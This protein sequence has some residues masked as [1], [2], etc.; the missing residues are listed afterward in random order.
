MN[1]DLANEL[2]M[3]YFDGENNDIEEAQLKQHLKTCKHCNDEFKCMNEIFESVENTN[4]VE[5]PES[6]ELK[7]MEKVECFESK[8]KE[9]NA[10]LLVILYNAATVLSIVLMIIFVADIKHI[11]IYSSFHKIVEY[12]NSFTSVASALLGVVNDLFIVISGIVATLYRVVLSIGKAYYG[13][14][15]LLLV[16]LFVIQRLFVIVAAKDWGKS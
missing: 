10:N 11:N 14:F 15:I 7:V 8:R 3:K 16:L 12:F 4:T 6:F 2:I 5:P 1:C 13:V 9:K